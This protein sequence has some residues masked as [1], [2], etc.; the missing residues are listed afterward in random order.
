MRCEK[1]SSSSSISAITTTLVLVYHGNYFE[2]ELIVVCHCF[3]REKF[4]ITIF[5]RYRTLASY[6]LPPHADDHE[7]RYWWKVDLKHFPLNHEARV[8]ATIP[9]AVCLFFSA[10]RPTVRYLALSP[11]RCFQRLI[12]SEK[13]PYKCFALDLALSKRAWR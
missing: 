12:I 2:T 7:K 1:L 13:N 8:I 4:F 5:G 6:T 10:N 11:V 3:L 9:T